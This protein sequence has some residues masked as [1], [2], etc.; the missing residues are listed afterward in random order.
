MAP[1]ISAPAARPIVP[2]IYKVFINISRP[3]PILP[4]FSLAIL[5]FCPKL[6]VSQAPASID[7]LSPLFIPKQACHPPAEFLFNLTQHQA[8]QHVARS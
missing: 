3:F 6:F 5:P 1:A 4:I 2:A 7:F 8:T